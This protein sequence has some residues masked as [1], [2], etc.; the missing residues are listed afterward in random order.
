VILLAPKPKDM[1]DNVLKIFS[2]E[3]LEDLKKD[4]SYTEVLNEVMKAY[5]DK[6]E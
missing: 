5:Q 3:D 1:R 6:I 2:V 4:P